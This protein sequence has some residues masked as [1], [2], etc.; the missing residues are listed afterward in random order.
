MAILLTDQCTAECEMCCFGCSPKNNTVMQPE[1][2]RRI[3]DE[4]ALMSGIQTVGF[5][6]GEAFLQYDMLSD[7]IKYATELGLRTTCTTNGFWA[8]SY[9]KA[10]KKLATLKENGLA[11]LGLSMDYFHQHFVDI[12]NLKNILIACKN[13]GISVDIGSVITKSNSDL[14]QLLYV[15]KDYMI[16]VPHFRAACLPIGKAKNIDSSD[17][18]YD[19]DL[20][21][22]GQ[23]QCYELTYFSVYLN[24]DVYPCCSQAGMI[25]Y[26]KLGNIHNDTIETILAKYRGNMHIRIIKKHGLSW[27]IEIAKKENFNDILNKKYV[28]KCDLCHSIFSNE[29]FMSCVHKYVQAE[30][31]YIYKK[32]ISTKGN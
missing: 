10:Y 16:N 4:A 14:T 17:L 31:E 32:Y 12:Q 20:L 24:G 18:Y 6:G 21:D 25:S 26:L 29:L 23:I 7:M 5:S 2:I 28:N 9:E 19:D 13:L 27:Y 8:S 11:K 30:K 3:I 22:R 15:L 1:V